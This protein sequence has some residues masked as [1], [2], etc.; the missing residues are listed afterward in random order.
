MTF[1]P[2]T[3][4]RVPS[5]T[6]ARIHANLAAIDILERLRREDRRFATADEQAVLAAF[7]V[8]SSRSKIVV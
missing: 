6:K 4:V 2:G 8:R 5:G 1:R 3:E 7:C